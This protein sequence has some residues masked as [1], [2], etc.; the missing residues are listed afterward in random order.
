MTDI[1]ITTDSGN[2]FDY[3]RHTKQLTLLF[4]VYNN[5]EYLLGI[6][7]NK[8]NLYVCSNYILYP[9]YGNPMIFN[10]NPL[11][12]HIK[13]IG[14]YLFL[15]GI[16]NTI[17][18]LNK[19]LKTHIGTIWFRPTTK[20]TGADVLSNI[21]FTGE[22]FYVQ[23]ISV[24]TDTNQNAFFE[25]FPR[26]SGAIRLDKNM[27][28]IAKTA[29]GKEIVLTEFVD[30]KFYS[31][32]NYLDEDMGGLLVDG[33]LKI[34]WD[35]RYKI[36][37]M[38]IEDNE[39]FLVGEVFYNMLGGAILR[40]DRQFNIIDRELFGGYGCFLGC[41][42]ENDKTNLYDM[43][44][45]VSSWDERLEKNGEVKIYKK[46]IELINDPI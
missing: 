32:C 22:E 31:I 38:V 42:S 14:D 27:N 6:T 36:H 17:V 46:E 16:H 7:K 41:T 29:F 13:C 20:K 40:L 21:T 33:E 18:V 25:E 19:D 44:I 9:S 35:S 26:S 1:L 11:I 23:F 37:D 3:N 8:E 39:I 30:G 2:L 10:R 5:N 24:A 15:P 45:D 28:L 43:D 4:R 34:T 12:Q